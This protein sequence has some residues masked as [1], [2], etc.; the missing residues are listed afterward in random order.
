MS[1]VNFF[2]RLILIYKKVNGYY[3]IPEKSG[4]E[5]IFYF[6]NKFRYKKKKKK[7]EKS[8]KKLTQTFFYFSFLFR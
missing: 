6:S 2:F 5:E 8:L 7:S 1:I 3:N 4:K